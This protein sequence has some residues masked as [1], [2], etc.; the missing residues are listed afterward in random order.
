MNGYTIVPSSFFSKDNARKILAELVPIQ[1][2]DKVNYQELPEHGAVL[3]YC[4]DTV[5]PIATLIGRL[6]SV[7]EY[8]RVLFLFD[9]EAIH[10]AV[11][12]GERLL[13]ANSF[14]ANDFVT[15]EYFLFASLKEFQ[16][17]PDVTTLYYEGEL[18]YECR[19]ELF[20][21]FSGVESAKSLLQAESEL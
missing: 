5:P 7:K 16:I 2:E 20:K 13:F 9:G 8:N 14:P 18:S 17:N 10:L 21:Y 4:G 1:K 19:E 11:G 3:V 15:A 12:E 6:R